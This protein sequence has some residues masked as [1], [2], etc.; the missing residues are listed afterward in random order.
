MCIKGC[1]SCEEGGSKLREIY[2][3]FFSCKF[4]YVDAMN[5]FILFIA[6]TSFVVIWVIASFIHALLK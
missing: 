6:I 1:L 5:Y 2:V 4:I 3:V